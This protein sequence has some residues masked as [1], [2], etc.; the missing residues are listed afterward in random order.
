MGQDFC[1]VKIKYTKGEEIKFISHLDHMRVLERALR[2][3]DLPIAYSQ[4]FNPRPKIA[5]LTRALKVGETSEA[6][7][8]ELTFEGWIKAETVKVALNQVLPA[9]FLI[10]SSEISTK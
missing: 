8:A 3:A 10:I 1:K 5:Y 9:G 2:R 6:C 7:E 4:G